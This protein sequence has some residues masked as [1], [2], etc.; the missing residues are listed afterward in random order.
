[1]VGADA[2]CYAKHGYALLGRV[3]SD[4]DLQQL[5]A[6][7]LRFRPAR[8]HGRRANRTLRVAVQLCHRSEPVRRMATRGP[9][10]PA[11]VQLVGP[12]VCLTH[13]QFVTKLSDQ[14][15]VGAG[16]A[17]DDPTHSDIPWHQDSGYGQLDPPDDLTVFFAL[18]DMDQSSGCL[19]VVPGSHLSGLHE[20]D[21]ASI[22]PALRET[23]SRGDGV[24]VLLRAGEAL[25]F[26][27]L[28][29]H[30]SP[31]NHGPAPR[32]AFYT[33][34]CAPWVRMM[35]EAGRPVLEDPHSWMV[36]GEAPDS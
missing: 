8:S 32:V 22:N 6:E 20:H 9:H 28:L 2:E 1:M 24:P 18:T 13:V 7:E 31:A 30:G 4:E 14:P 23:R 15:G 29:I 10:I 5:L 26:S 27:G 34:Y 19:H 12:D 25:A 33:R 17:S 3:L 16:L 21:A 35:S 36:A 11:V